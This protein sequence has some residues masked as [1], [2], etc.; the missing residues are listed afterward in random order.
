MRTTL[1]SL[2]I[3][4]FLYRAGMPVS[5]PF[6]Q[7]GLFL[8]QEAMG[9]KLDCGFYL[10]RHGP[11]SREIFENILTLEQEGKVVIS[12][13]PRGFQIEVTD[14][15]REFVNKGGEW[16]AFFDVPPVRIPEDRID[17]IFTLIGRDSPV[18]MECMGTALFL[19]LTAGADAFLDEL[20]A[21][22][23]EKKLADEISDRSV[24]EAL[25]RL[26]RLGIR[27]SGDE[28]L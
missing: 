13:S 21:A 28:S 27:L 17:A 22:K 6:I 4:R 16:G 15:G 11:R 2:C 18:G 25:R 12:G 9:E 26:K 8:L 5:E 19:A 3:L 1:R 10:D 23:E 24:V 20:H 7:S 14:R